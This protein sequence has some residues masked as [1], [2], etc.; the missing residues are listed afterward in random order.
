LETGHLWAI[1]SGYFIGN[2]GLIL[3][4]FDE[5]V[6]VE[7]INFD[8][9]I[10]G[11]VV[12]LKWATATETNNQGFY[13]QRKLYNKSEWFDI[14]FVE[15]KGTTTQ[16]NKYLFKD[17]LKEKGRYS[18][19]LKQTDFDGTVKYSIEILIKYDFPNGFIVGV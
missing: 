4:Y 18:Y 1:N 19:R 6:P 14:G 11:N 5:T 17:E 3:K 7:L 9:F 2:T 15:G 8:G 16:Q 12:Y 13:I 10:N